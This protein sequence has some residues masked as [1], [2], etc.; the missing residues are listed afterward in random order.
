MLPSGDREPSNPNFQGTDR[1]A[2]DD[3]VRGGSGRRGG[4]MG[5]MPRHA[6]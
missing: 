5:R 4:S 1:P 2:A 3:E 6:R